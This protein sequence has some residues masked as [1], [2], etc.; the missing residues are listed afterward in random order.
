MTKLGYPKAVL[1]EEQKKLAVRCCLIALGHL[2]TNEPRLMHC[3][4]RLANI[5]WSP[6]PFLTDLELAHKEPWKVTFLSDMHASKM[7]LEGLSTNM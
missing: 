6:E 7:I 4:V 1:T 2:H 3:D 5:L